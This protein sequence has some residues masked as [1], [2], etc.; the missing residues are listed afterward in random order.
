MK[1]TVAFGVLAIFLAYFSRS[2]SGFISNRLGVS[3]LGAILADKGYLP[4]AVIRVGAAMKIQTFIDNLPVTAK[5][6]YEWELQFTKD[7]KST[8]HIALSTQR[9][10]EQ[11]YEVPAE[12]FFLVLGRRLKYSMSLFNDPNDTLD[13]AAFNMLG[14]YVK[15]AGLQSSASATILDLGCGW[16]SLTMFL[17][18]YCPKC[19]IVSL[20]NSFSQAEFISNRAKESKLT[21]IE[22]KTANIATHEFSPE[23]HEKFDFIFSIEMFEH[24]KNYKLLLEKIS[25]LLKPAGKLF[26]H[27]FTA[28][29]PYHHNDTSS[30]MD[31]HFFKDGTMPSPTLLYNF[32][33]SLQIQKKWL[34]DGSHYMHTANRWL[35][36]MDKNA[37]RIREIFRPVY[38]KDTE[39]WFQ[40]WRIFFLAV[41]ESW[42]NPFYH[43]THLLWEKP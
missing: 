41:S 7:L 20:S 28:D 42:T 13:Q 8:R 3:N 24:M 17:A 36:N 12:F 32:Q 9:A 16:G 31:E 6:R 37:K 14:S 39:L 33:D 35:E 18:Q 11:H 4:D 30:W 15:K 25:K 26:I 10:N 27:F 22:T 1:L 29:V 34:L 23:M 43:V 2:F 21:N 40:R 5:E 38:K 19:K